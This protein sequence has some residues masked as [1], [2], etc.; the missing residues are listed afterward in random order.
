MGIPNSRYEGVGNWSSSI[1]N[2]AG[3]MLVK[4]KEHIFETAFWTD[5]EPGAQDLAEAN[6]ENNSWRIYD[7]PYDLKKSPKIE[8]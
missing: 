8:N 4:H 5:K 6:P 3:K 2:Y 7:E 1:P